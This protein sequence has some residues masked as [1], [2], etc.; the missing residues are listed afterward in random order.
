MN[1]AAKFQRQVQKLYQLLDIAK[2]LTTSGRLARGELQFYELWK[3]ENAHAIALLSRVVWYWEG[4]RTRF[5]ITRELA[6][7]QEFNTYSRIGITQI[8]AGRK[9]PDISEAVKFI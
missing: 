1:L 3:R 4:N 5:S 2:I 9:R 6:A 8:L 7:H